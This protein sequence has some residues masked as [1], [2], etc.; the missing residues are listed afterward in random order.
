MTGAGD[1]DMRNFGRAIL[2]LWG[3]DRKEATCHAGDLGSIP[4]WGGGWRKND[5]PLQPSCQEIPWT[6]E[7][8]GLQPRGPHRGGHDCVA[9]TSTFIFG[10]VVTLL[11]T[12]LES[13]PNPASGASPAS[14]LG[15]RIYN[16]R[17]PGVVVGSAGSP[18]LSCKPG[19]FM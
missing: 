4:G 18:G 2:I 10:G 11:A 12:N 3:S 17:W 1:W 9:H 15:C 6:E 16:A 7:P 19:V 8:G 13:R 5:Y 14:T